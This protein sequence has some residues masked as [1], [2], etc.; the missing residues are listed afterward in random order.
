MKE[1][2]TKSRLNEFYYVRNDLLTL[3]NLLSESVKQDQKSG[4]QQDVDFLNIFKSTLDSW[5]D[6]DQFDTFQNMMFS[7][8][9]G[10]LF[11]L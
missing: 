4:T 6:V 10:A 8:D 2:I 1:G 5:M 11:L 7:C 9:A 3:Q